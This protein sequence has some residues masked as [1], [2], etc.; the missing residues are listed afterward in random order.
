MN[1]INPLSILII[2]VIAGA[3]VWFLYPSITFYIQP[4]EKRRDIIQNHPDVLKK[5]INLGLDLQGGLRLV[6]EVDRS[7]L[8]KDEEK[9]ILDRAYAVIENRVNKY[10]VAEP[11]IQKQGSD[12]LIVELPGIQDRNTAIKV[13][14]STAQL[15]FKLLREPTELDKAIR[16][17]DKTLK[18]ERTLASAED[19]VATDTAAVEEEEA[20]AQAE[21][22]FAGEDAEPDT[23]SIE[24]VDTLKDIFAV[25]S[26]S[27]NLVALGD[28][29]AVLEKNKR[30][31]ET[32]FARKD[33]SDAL[34]K[35]GLGGSE[36]LW[37]H[38]IEKRG[39]EEYR[40]LYYLKR[41][42]ELKGNIIKDARWE[43]AR[44]GLEAG[45]AIVNLEMN[46]EGARRFS[47]VTGVNVHKF[48]A[49]ILDSTVYSAPQIREKIP[50]GRA[51][52]T[53]RFSNEEAKALA[54]VLR[55]GA[56]PAPVKIIEERTVGPSLGQDSIK[57]AVNACILGFILIVLFMLIYYKGA[58]VI[59]DG[60]L[61]LNLILVL[62]IL[63]SFGLTLT[64]P[65]I[66]GLI[67]TIG[68]AID[69]NVIIFE[70]I[71][72]EL[73]IGKT[74]RSA[75]DA[76]YSRAFVTIMDA[77]ITTLFTAAILLWVGT[78]PVKGFAVVMIIGIIVS[79]ITALFITRVVFN[80][81]T[82]SKSI[83]KLSI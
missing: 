19:T 37:A 82:A 31:V 7:N 42:A 9:D 6:L 43:I 16:T 66:A 40:P 55:A 26:F 63:A 61:I 65:G 12:R 44:G 27:E 21:K 10:G 80:M 4:P 69:A 45:Q 78:G 67:L 58:G 11:I 74:I 5:V 81:I 53:G 15:E 56:L 8:S 32:I 38:D 3:A 23:E 13:I 28:M 59:A 70:R 68:M 71:R 49:I 51:Q 52:I 79:L 29:V 73:A 20:Q 75:V 57:K 22:L 64:L 54:I 2:L 30:K 25:K 18:G 36:F 41:K 77:N 50:Q 47:R 62:A 39:N 14:K 35:A 72:E 46:R 24:E 17:I 83:K 1:K 76:G 60:A 33:V 48:L 34:K